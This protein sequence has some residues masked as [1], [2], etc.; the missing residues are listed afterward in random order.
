MQQLQE[1][2]HKT[3]NEGDHSVGH[4]SWTKKKLIGDVSRKRKNSD[5]D[6]HPRKRS[7]MKKLRKQPK[8][9]LKYLA[10]Q[11]TSELSYLKVEQKA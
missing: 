2:R 10:S 5:T 7:P 4:H 1:R 6:Y 3:E 11:L 8:P 9:F